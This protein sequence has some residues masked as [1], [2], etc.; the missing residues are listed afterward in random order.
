M[1]EDRNDNINADSY[2]AQRKSKVAELIERAKGENRSYRKYAMDAGISCAALTRM[3]KGDYVPK[4]DTI[5]KLTS[6]KA[7]PRGGV[8][9]EEM[10]LT[11]GYAVESKYDEDW[12]AGLA[13]ST[14]QAGNPEIKSEEDREEKRRR[15]REENERRRKSE[16]Q[17]EV[18]AKF[19]I[20]NALFD[21]G[22]NVKRLDEPISVA[23]QGRRDM[24]LA[25]YDQPIAR[26]DFEY[27][28]IGDKE[29]YSSRFLAERWFGR[30]LFLGIP[31]DSKLS[32]VVNDRS[33]YQYLERYE[34]KLAFRGE[35]SV[36][37][38]NLE[39][40]KVDGEFYLSNFQPGDTSRE[41]YLYNRI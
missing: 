26:W 11:A 16:M 17:F 21:R 5:E 18:A 15:S 13:E 19:Q 20:V 29:L 1:S 23:S 2:S 24:M 34:H 25:L 35:L 39:E 4:P 33:F 40:G 9:F 22:I 41:I 3:R 7:R 37:F 8:T 30:E 36:I 27:K 31:E 32:Y 12:R 14:D 6:Q 38:V 28:Y 10:M